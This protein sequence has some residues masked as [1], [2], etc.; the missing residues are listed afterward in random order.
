MASLVAVQSVVE[1]ATVRKSGHWHPMLKH[2]LDNVL[3][4]RENPSRVI[5]ETF[6]GGGPVAKLV[7]VRSAVTTAAMQKANGMPGRSV[8][9]H[10]CSGGS[11]GRSAG[12]SRSFRASMTSMTAAPVYWA[13]VAA[14]AAP[15]C[16]PQILSLS[17]AEA[18]GFCPTIRNCSGMRGCCYWTTYHWH[19]ARLQDWHTVAGSL[20][21]HRVFAGCL[22]H[23]HQEQP[24][25]EC[26]AT[27]SQR[28]APRQL[29]KESCSISI[30]NLPDKGWV[31]Q[32]GTV[33]QVFCTAWL[34]SFRQLS[35][36]SHLPT[37]FE[38]LCQARGRCRGFSAP[39]VVAH[40]SQQHGLGSH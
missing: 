17:H 21:K 16:K 26:L 12:S 7:A 22:P 29:P 32:A 18:S 3:L 37:C 33:R 1:V 4:R 30:H 6:S 28:S 5:H 36:V 8:S 11:L 39:V 40:A 14:L 9:T 19:G 10:C 34:H 27:G 38:D 13:A 24:P 25:K 35:T 23:Q 15:D 31:M 20:S 2:P